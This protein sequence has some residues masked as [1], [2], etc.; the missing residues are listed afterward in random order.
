MSPGKQFIW[1]VVKEITT[2]NKH[3]L[4]EFAIVTL[5]ALVF[6]AEHDPGLIRSLQ[7]NARFINLIV[8]SLFVE[9]KR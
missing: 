3:K 4:A 7:S 8:I 2:C 6:I 5:L 9:T 1:I